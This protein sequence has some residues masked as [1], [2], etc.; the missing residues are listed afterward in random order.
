M[1][2]WRFVFVIIVVAV[3]QTSAAMNLL[4]LTDLRIS[5]DIILILLV[6]FAVYCDVYDAVII[7]FAFGF[8]ADVAGGVMGPHFISYGIVGSAIAHIRKIILLKKTGQQ[9]MTVFVTGILTESVVL[10]L[11]GLKAA[12]L[13]KAGVFEIFAV[14]GYSAILWFLIKWPVTKI[15]KWLGVGVHRFGLRADGRV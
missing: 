15:G 3:L 9:A 13:A 8:A 1:R 5:P 14:S 10:I 12:G 4:S 11:T 7:S 2:W 6:Y